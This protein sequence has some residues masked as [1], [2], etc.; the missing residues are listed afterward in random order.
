[1]SQF[2]CNFGAEFVSIPQNS[3]SGAKI[4][5]NFEIYKYNREKR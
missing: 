2:F 3:F 5:Q 1:M 4:R